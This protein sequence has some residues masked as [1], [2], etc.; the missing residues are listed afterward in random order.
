MSSTPSMVT[1]HL[2]ELHKELTLN[3]Y[4]LGCPGMHSHVEWKTFGNS[5]L[6]VKAVKE[7]MSSQD[8]AAQSDTSSS[9]CPSRPS[10]ENDTE[11]EP[12]VLVFLARVS[13][14]NY[15]FAANGCFKQPV[16]KME[17]IKPSCLLEMPQFSVFSDDFSSVVDNLTLL[18]NLAATKGYEKQG[19]VKTEGGVN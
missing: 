12:A 3:Y 15:F 4:Y 18:E 17:S 8:A 7:P 9:T 6:L 2:L 11:Q 1:A 10:V 5:K 13:T 16:A 19:I 14:Q